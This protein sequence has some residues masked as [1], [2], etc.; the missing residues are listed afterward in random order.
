MVAVASVVV[1]QLPVAVHLHDPLVEEAV[2]VEVPAGEL[3]VDPAE[4]VLDVQRAGRAGGDDQQASDLGDGDRMQPQRLAV[5]PREAV[6]GQRLAEEVTVQVIGPGVVRTGEHAAGVAVPLDNTRPSVAAG[7]EER[8]DLAVLTPHEEGRDVADVDG[9]AVTG[10]GQVARQR[11]HQRP[12][13]EQQ[14]LLGG[15]S[16][17]VDVDAHVVVAGVERHV[18]GAV[19]TQLQEAVDQVDLG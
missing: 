15:C 18:G 11:G 4:P 17:F 3:V 6:A 10:V 9:H 1:G 13:P 12:A 7:V 2:A 16:S 8:A 5:L 14:R 19:G